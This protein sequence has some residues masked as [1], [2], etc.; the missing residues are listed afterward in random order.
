MNNKDDVNPA[1]VHRLVG[2]NTESARSCCRFH[3]ESD[4]GAHAIGKDGVL[5][6]PI[7]M[8]FI[9]CKVCGNKRCPKATDCRQDCTGSNEPLQV[10]SV[11]D[12]PNAQ[13]TGPKAPVH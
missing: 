8:P 12:P 11:Y 9:V 5:W 10:G 13:I 4:A 7:G 2:R 6:N 3:W 1:P